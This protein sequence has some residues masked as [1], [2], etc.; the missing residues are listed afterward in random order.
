MNKIIRCECGCSKILAITDCGFLFDIGYGTARIFKEKDISMG[1][2]SNY[3]FVGAEGMVISERNAV[4]L[5][6]FLGG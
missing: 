6:Q 2:H 3:L 1:K 4:V 5:R